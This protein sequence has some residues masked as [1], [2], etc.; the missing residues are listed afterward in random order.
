M[1]IS[2][3]LFSQIITHIIASHKLGDD[4]YNAVSAYNKETHDCADC[5]FLPTRLEDDLVML[6]ELAMNDEDGWISY[7]LYELDCGEKY[8]DGCILDDNDNSIPCKTIK[9]LYELVMAE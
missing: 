2:F 9:E 3:D 5:S 6:L 8:K 1:Y 4:I 7:W